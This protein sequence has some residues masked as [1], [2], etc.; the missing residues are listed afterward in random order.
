MISRLLDTKVCVELIRRRS[1]RVLARF[2]EEPSGTLG[3][4]SITAA[5]LFDGAARSSNPS[6]GAE[7]LAEF[8]G[9]FELL[10]FDGAAAQVYG[11]VRAG[12]ERAGR[13]AGPL[14]TLIAA[15]ALSLG[16]ILVT[17]NVREFRRVPG[18]QVENWLRA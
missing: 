10:P 1:P 4:S 8:L 6:M 15:Q 18:L 2:R 16:A 5:E 9:A 12:L 3:L 7:A 11:G 13:P 17:D 14:D